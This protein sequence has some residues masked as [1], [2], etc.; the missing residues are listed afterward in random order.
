MSWEFQGRPFEAIHV[1]FEDLP[2][3]VLTSILLFATTSTLI[4]GIGIVE[5]SLLQLD[6]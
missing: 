3:S 2:L 6:G 5:K 4:L 1:Y